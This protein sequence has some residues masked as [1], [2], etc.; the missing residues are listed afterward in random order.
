MPPPTRAVI[1]DWGGVFTRRPPGPTRRALERRL[2]LQPGGLDAFFSEDA[3]LLFSTGRQTKVDFWAQVCAGFPVPPDI[4]TASA[5]WAHLFEAPKVRP[6]LVEVLHHL[7]GRVRLGLLSN[8]GPDLRELVTPLAGLFDDI[9]ISAEVRFRKPEPEIYRLALQKLGV[10]P[11]E[12]LF[13]DD[14]PR[15]VD[16]ARMLGLQ[17]YR[18]VTPGRLKLVLAHRGLLGDTSLFW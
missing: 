8:A 15:N 1:F 6:Q 13:I 2:G 7:R 18:F 9:V 14:L 4:T 3:W 16:A 17:A 12:T 5:V 10:E 11:A